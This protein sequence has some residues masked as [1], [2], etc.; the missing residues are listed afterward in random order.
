MNRL[1]RMWFMVLLSVGWT[2][3]VL[4]G[5]GMWTTTG[6]FGGQIHH[7]TTHPTQPLTLI[8]LSR[9]GLFRTFDGGVTWERA[10]QGIG[11]LVSPLLPALYD[12]DQPNTVYVLDSAYRVMRS[13]DGGDNW[14]A[15]GATFPFALTNPLPQAWVDVPGNTG[16]ILMA[17]RTGTVHLL[18]STDSG[19]TF[20][21]FGAGLPA[22]SVGRALAFDPGNNN[23]VMLGM[24]QIDGVTNALFH[25]S[26]AG[27]NWTQSACTACTAAPL[28]RGAF[29]VGYGPGNTAY[30]VGLGRL[31]VSTD[32]GATFSLSAGT[33]T[34]STAPARIVVHPTAVGTVFFSFNLTVVSG[35]FRTTDSGATITQVTSGLTP[36]TSYTGT[37]APNNPVPALPTALVAETGFGTVASRRIWLATDGAGLFRATDAAMTG[38]TPLDPGGANLNT[39][40][41]AANI[42]AL[43]IN[44]NPSAR[45]GPGFPGNRIYA[46]FGDTAVSSP[47]LYRSTNAGATWN[48]ANNQLRAALVRAITIDP[49]TVGISVADINQSVIYA[50]GRSSVVTG[51]QNGGL[52]KSIDNGSSWTTIDNGLPLLSG[53][54]TIGNVR[55]LILDPRSCTPQ[56]LPCLTPLQ[57]MFAAADGFPSLTTVNDM[58]VFTDTTDY[59]HR[60]VRGTGGGANWVASDTGLPPSRRIFTRPANVEFT[61]GVTPLPLV[62]SPTNS[63]V[64][65]LGT[66]LTERD[67]DPNRDFVDIQNGMFKSV[68]GGATWTFISNGLPLRTGRTNTRF[69]V[70][71][72]AIHPTNDQILWA[73]VIDSGV[74]GTVVGSASIYK[75]INGGTTWFESADGVGA[76]LDIRALA[77]DTSDTGAGTIYASGAGSASNPGSVYKSIDG[78]AT[79]R[80]ISVGLPEEAALSIIVDPFVPAQLHVGTT[81]GV[82]S[83]LQLPDDDNDGIPNG[84]ENNAP[85]SGDGNGDATLDSAQPDVGSTGVALRT[86]DGVGGGFITSD[87]ISGVGPGNCVQ[88]VDVQARTALR[89]GRDAIP[90]LPNFFYGYP[91]ELIRFEIIDCE[92]AIIDVTFHNE[93]FNEYGWRFRF[94]GPSIPGDDATIGWYPLS[95]GSNIRATLLDSNTW[96]LTLEANEYGSYRPSGDNILFMGGPACFDDRLFVHGME[97]NNPLTPPACN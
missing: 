31:Y 46:G 38:F 44:T 14:A 73:S 28:F 34:G 20:V 95:D 37:V 9:G 88:A 47:A 25:S 1:M 75:T 2:T 15:T 64:L 61:Q 89:Y 65:Y 18:R 12:V 80:S 69:D 86:P 71:A 68:D 59:T 45:Q 74:N 90:G 33:F 41:S 40:L 35:V 21:P 54:P 13:T 29:A 16:Q 60:V 49:T 79:W 30:A 43:A 94:H 55:S 77:V 53:V 66:L 32:G 24:S 62:M 22:G 91:N 27:A 51:Y 10:E 92:S 70:L 7:L 78:G 81:A 6:P 50:A 63:S 76:L 42:R 17:I 58:G 4:A 87:I 36:N 83:Q 39:G 11:P 8:A 57:T 26:D 52:Y 96:R 19:A 85:G 84:E 93:N 72:L 97:T 3:P 23:R 5:D 82:W 67:T 48:T 56:I